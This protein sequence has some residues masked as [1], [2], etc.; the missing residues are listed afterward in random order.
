MI[1]D[2][3]IIDHSRIGSAVIKLGAFSRKFPTKI[4]ESKSGEVDIVLSL[5]I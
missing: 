3:S 5:Q 1:I 4:S 2:H